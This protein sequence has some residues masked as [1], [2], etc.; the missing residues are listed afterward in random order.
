MFDDA[1]CNY[2]YTTQFGMNAPV[3]GTCKTTSPSDSAKPP[4]P[5]SSAPPMP[6]SKPPMPSGTTPPYPYESDCEDVTVTSWTSVYKPKATG[7]YTPTNGTMSKS[8][9]QPPAATYS[10]AQGGAGRL[11]AGASGVVAV[12]AAALL[13]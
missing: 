9:P 12:L 2:Q 13:L 4:M 1:T 5:S 6:S 10:P 8:S 7:G 11:V 3:A